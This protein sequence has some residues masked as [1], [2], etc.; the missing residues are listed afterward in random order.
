MFTFSSLTSRKH[1]MVST[2][3]VLLKLWSN[4][5]FQENLLEVCLNNTESKFKIGSKITESIQVITELR[6]D[7]LSP[8]LFNLAM[9]KIKRVTDQQ[10]FK[11]ISIGGE[12]MSLIAYAE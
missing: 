9:D 11:D 8:F 6:Q 12:N 3:L 7:G 2:Q 10:N 4:S 5:A 1:T